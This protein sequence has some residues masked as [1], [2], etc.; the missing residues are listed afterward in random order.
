MTE[1]D[2]IGYLLNLLDTSERAAVETWLAQ[3]AEA[4][5]Q[6]RQLQGWLEALT[7][8]DE[9]DPPADLTY[10]TLRR[11]VAFEVSRR[12]QQ[13]PATASAVPSMALSPPATGRRTRRADVFVLLA[14][15]ALLGALLPPA[16]LQA[17]HRQQI[18]AC[19]NNLRLM[20]AM[21]KC[22][23]DHHGGQ[24][25]CIPEH[26]PLAFAGAFVLMLREAKTWDNGITMVCPANRHK[27]RNQ[28]GLG[29]ASDCEYDLD[30]ID[31]TTMRRWIESG[32]ENLRERY[33]KVCQQLGGCY[34]Y[35][36]GYRDAYGRLHGL[37]LGDEGYVPVLADRPPRCEEEPLHWQKLNSPNHSK[38]GQNVLFLSGHVRFQRC[39]HCNGIDEDIYLN[40]H[41]ELA[42]GC[43][44]RDAVLGPSEAS[45]C[46]IPLADNR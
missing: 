41:K 32:H 31:S 46:G 30:K 21:L 28:C 8:G 24:L 11:V 18:L 34:A 22:Y 12:R 33:R 10:R 7:L 38:F 9:T 35:H 19:E 5:Q 20:H 40:R 2:L 42:A 29:S 6:L 26:G 45:P 4:Q 37:R 1:P 13:T 15:T 16:V 43:D 23:A 25:P 44:P 39:R 27:P 17:R 36:L 3:S 14:L